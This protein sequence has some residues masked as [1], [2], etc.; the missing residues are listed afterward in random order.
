MLPLGDVHVGVSRTRVSSSSGGS[1]ATNTTAAAQAYGAGSILSSESA[2]APGPGAGPNSPDSP[3]VRCDYYIERVVGRG[4]FGVVYEAK[5][6][7]TGRTVAIKKVV[8]HP[9]YKVSVPIG[10]KRG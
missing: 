7:E 5:V 3:L 2:T 4:T 6:L 10:A 9:D 1:S 8:Q